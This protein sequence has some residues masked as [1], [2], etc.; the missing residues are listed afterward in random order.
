MSGE[1]EKSLRS[2][3]ALISNSLEM[4]EQRYSMKYPKPKFKID[5]NLSCT[6]YGSDVEKTKPLEKASNKGSNIR[7]FSTINA[8]LG[9][10]DDVLAL[11]SITQDIAMSQSNNKF[12]QK[13]LEIVFYITDGEAQD[14][15]GMKQELDS[16]DSS[17][18]WRGIQVANASTTFDEVWQGNINRRGIQVDAMSELP[19][20]VAELLQD[21]LGH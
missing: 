19:K 1:G 16:S 17:V 9:G 4:Y 20:A 3:F 8:N 21:I 13:P 14:P 2:T 7:A 5:F 11:K 10:T 12:K 15:E 6:R 18:L